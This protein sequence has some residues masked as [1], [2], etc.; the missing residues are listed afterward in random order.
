MMIS[1]REKLYATR[2]A[3]FLR[4]PRVLYLV[5][6]DAILSFVHE[7]LVEINVNKSWAA[8]VNVYEAIDCFL[9]GPP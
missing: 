3:K 6:L 2:L 5:N 7:H 1:S 9:V 4:P 8:N